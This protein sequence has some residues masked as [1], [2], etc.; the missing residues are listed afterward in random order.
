MKFIKTEHPESGACLC[1]LDETALDMMMEECKVLVEESGVGE[2]II[3]TVVEMT[4]EEASKLPEF[5]G[6]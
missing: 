5:Q 6:W 4:E 3:F 2:S 1:K